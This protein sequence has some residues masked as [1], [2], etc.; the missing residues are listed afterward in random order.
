MQEENITNKLLKKIDGLKSEKSAI[1][2]HF[3]A[4]SE[5]ISNNLM[6]Q[7][8]QLQKEKIELEQAMEVEQEFM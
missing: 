3:E 1:A 6:R 4:D 8:K 2:S 7:L 5:S